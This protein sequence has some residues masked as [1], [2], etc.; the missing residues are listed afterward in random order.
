M[1]CRHPVTGSCPAVSTLTADQCVGRHSTC[2]S[3]GVP[4]LDC[5][6]WGLCCFDGC[7]NTCVGDTPPPP[8]LP[9]YDPPAPRRNP[10]DPNPCGPGSMCIPQEGEPTCKCPE[11]MIPNPTPQQGCIVPNPCDPNPCG[12][13]AMCIPQ[14]GRPF[15]KC[16]EPLIPDPTPEIQ[17]SAR[18]PCDP[19]PCGPGTTCTPNRDGNPICRCLPG[20]IPKPDTITG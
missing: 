14:E 10:C 6:D 13:N 3:V 18:D 8:P 19:S 1:L 17:C 16:P 2:W 5:P 15:C 12:R 7:A 11:G 20:L 9:S 4:D